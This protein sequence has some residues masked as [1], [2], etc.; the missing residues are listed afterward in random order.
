[1]RRCPP[2]ARQK[3]HNRR[4]DLPVGF[5]L[6]KGKDVITYGQTESIKLRDAGLVL[7]DGFDWLALL[8]DV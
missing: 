7:A 6:L 8:I 2:P 4:Q 3:Y 1:M 5:S